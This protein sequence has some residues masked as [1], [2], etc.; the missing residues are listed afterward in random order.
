MP[1]SRRSFLGR[2]AAGLSAVAA[3]SVLAG[4]S[5]GATTEGT[6]VSKPVDGKLNVTW[7]S[8]N[9]PSFVTANTTMIRRFEAEN[10]GIHIVY[11]YFPYDVLARKLQAAYRARNVADIQQMFGT[12]VTEYAVNQLLDEVPSE[13]SGSEPTSRFWPAAVGAYTHKGKLYGVPHEYNLENGGIL[14]NPKLAEQAGIKEPPSTWADLVEAG[15]RLTKIDSKG[16]AD[17]VGYAFTG[18]DSITFTFLSMIL[19]LGGDF[20]DSDGVHV[21]FH[22]P[23]ARKAWVDETELVTRHKVDNT[24][25]YTGDPYTMFFRGRAAMAHQG[26]WVVASGRADFPK[27]TDL[28]YVA[29]PP[30]A[31]DTLKF[32]AESG[33]GEVVNARADPKV[34]EAAWKFVG[35]MA[36]PDNARI[37][38]LT[39]ATVPALKELQNDSQML[40]KAPYLKVPFGVLPNGRWVGRVHD[41]DQFWTF[42]HDAFVSVELHRQDPV[43]AIADAEKQINLMIDEKIGP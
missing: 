12:W 4:C 39:S 5:S 42:V 17:Q 20:W 33:W 40:A 15:E 36:R 2:S 22:S 28:A 11:Q 32:A 8:H 27:F 1:L 6:V 3:G 25:W 14:Y 29:E 16:R 18:N 24:T 43:A 37:W 34:R 10:P 23:Q 26:P 7:W 31:G 9:N 38:N 35:F 13:L 30:Y 19:Q 41:R 21:D